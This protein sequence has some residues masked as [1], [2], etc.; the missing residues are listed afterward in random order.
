MSKRSLSPQ[1]G[2]AGF[3]DGLAVASAPVPVASGLS[4][5]QAQR[6]RLV[7]ASL[8]RDIHRFQQQLASLLV[9]WEQ[10]GHQTVEANVA[11]SFTLKSLVEWLPADLQ[12]LVAQ[13]LDLRACIVLREYQEV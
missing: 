13:F 2:P 12:P 7:A 5:E 10:Q 3:F 11:L 8:Q 6:V 1:H 9:S 4:P